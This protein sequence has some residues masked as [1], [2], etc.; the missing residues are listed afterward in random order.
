MPFVVKTNC[1]YRLLPDRGLLFVPWPAEFPFQPLM[2]W[3][4]HIHIPLVTS[5]VDTPRIK[6]P[7]CVSLSIGI[8]DL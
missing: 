7:F 1:G 4:H 5:S 8:I 2:P 3:D 6:Q